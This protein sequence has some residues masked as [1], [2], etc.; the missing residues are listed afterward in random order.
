[1]SPH[2]AEINELLIEGT[3]QQ[4]IIEAFPDLHLQSINI[5]G[6]KNHFKFV[7]KAIEKYKAQQ[8]TA[9]VKVI[10]EI[11]ALDEIYVKAHKYLTGVDFAETPPRKLEVVSE[12]M[13]RAIQTKADLCKD[14]TGPGAQI[15]ELFASVLRD[16][17]KVTKEIKMAEAIVENST[18]EA[19][20][21]IK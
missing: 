21:N 15:Q 12:M 7:N 11:E 5:T 18:I 1:M 13:L 17:R 6:H 2:C 3:P 8:E 19:E 10:T 14:T 9:V 16:A 20:Y 4:R